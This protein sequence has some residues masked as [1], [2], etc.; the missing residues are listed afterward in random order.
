MEKLTYKKIADSAI[1]ID[2]HNGYSVI[3][4]YGWYKG[5]YHSQFLLKNNQID[6][7]SLI[8]KLGKVPFKKA[9]YNNICYVLLKYVGNLV[10]ENFFEYY[11]ERYTYEVKCFDKGHEFFENEQIGR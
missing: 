3:A 2:L 11:I 9:N 8:E 6:N 5:C 4:L 10:D 1:I 7:W